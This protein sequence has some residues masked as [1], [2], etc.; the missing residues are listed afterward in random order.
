MPRYL[1]RYLAGDHIQVWDEFRQL[2]TVSPQSPSC[3]DVWPVVVE[4]MKRVRANLETVVERLRDDNYEFID[5]TGPPIRLGVPLATP[6]NESLEFLNWLDGLTG[7]LPLV[8]RAWLEH[9]GDVNFLGVHQAWLGKGMLTDPMVVEFE[10]RHCI[11][12]IDAREYYRE[13]LEEWYDC[14]GEEEGRFRISFAPDAL[15]KVNISGGGPYGIMVPDDNV[16]GI[17][18]INNRQMYFVDYLRECLAWGGF[19]G[20]AN[21]EKGRDAGRLA[22]L[23]E[24]LLPF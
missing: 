24:G 19:P 10:F 8:L 15:H 7:P 2:G 4:T 16:D 9:V 18:A 1:Q 13:E 20:F 5:T 3:D 6:D 12:S 17:V 21:I 14:G 23:A 11:E 22:R